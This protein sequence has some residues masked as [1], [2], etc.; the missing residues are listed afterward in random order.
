MN[1]VDVT[2]GFAGSSSRYLGMLASTMS[3]LDEAARHLE[4]AVAM[5]ERMGARPWL[6]HAQ[7]DYARVLLVRDTP[8]DRKRAHES[9]E[10]AVATYRELGMETHAERATALAEK[11]GAAA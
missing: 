4:D 11:V 3:R 6:A 10:S 1:A 9:V 7:H 2:E 5:N 8:G